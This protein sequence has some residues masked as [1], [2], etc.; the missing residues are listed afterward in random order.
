M[1]A[2]VHGHIKGM[3]FS[4]LLDTYG[5]ESE[6]ECR[7]WRRVRMVAWCICLLRSHRPPGDSGA[8]STVTVSKVLGR[9]HYPPLTPTPPLYC[10]DPRW[11]GDPAFFVVCDY[12]HRHTYRTLLREYQREEEKEPPAALHHSILQIRVLRYCSFSWAVVSHRGQMDWLH[13]DKEAIL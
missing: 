7:P 3:F 5:C 12:S 9:R 6:N 2:C 11:P 10:D 1:E 13:L 4:F 8:Q